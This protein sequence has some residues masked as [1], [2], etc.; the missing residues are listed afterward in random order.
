MLA[1]EKDH[2]EREQLAAHAAEITKIREETEEQ[3][4]VNTTDEAIQAQDSE[5]GTSSSDSE[6]EEPE[7]TDYIAVG[8]NVSIDTRTTMQHTALY[9]KASC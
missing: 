2:L 8:W 1:T 4:A 3:D 7:I 9:C 5:E 6:P